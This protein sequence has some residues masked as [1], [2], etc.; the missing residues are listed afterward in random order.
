[1]PSL[2]HKRPDGSDRLL[3]VGE[4]HLVIGRLP[5][6]DIMVR[7]PFVSRIHCDIGFAG[8][9]F[10]LKDLGSANGTYRNGARVFVCSL[11][12]GDKIQMGNTTL[13]FEIERVSGGGILRQVPQMPPPLRSPTTPGA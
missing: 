10:T 8:K 13:V 11:D 4:K 2:L 9:Q 12:S 1:M 6:S 7:D 5:E 3:E